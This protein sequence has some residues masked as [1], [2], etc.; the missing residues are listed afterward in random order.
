MMHALQHKPESPHHPSRPSVGPNSAE[1]DWL[2]PK[3]KRLLPELGLIGEQPPALQELAQASLGK[4]PPTW[5]STP[6]VDA[7]PRP[8]S[9]AKVGPTLLPAPCP[10]TTLPAI[11]IGN[12][13]SSCTQRGRARTQGM[14]PTSPQIERDVPSR[15]TLEVRISVPLCASGHESGPERLRCAMR[16]Y[17]C[18][19]HMRDKLA[20]TY[21]SSNPRQSGHKK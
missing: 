14:R 16:P 18:T 15:S 19:T 9:D 11:A 5:K 1:F 13:T 3:F 4:G 8:R 2:R 20:Y 17:G 7:T 10:S 12:T 6:T 21:K